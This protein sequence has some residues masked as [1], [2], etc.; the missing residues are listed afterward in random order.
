MS[1]KEIGRCSFLSG[2]NRSRNL[3]KKKKGNKNLQYLTVP[4]KHIML[5]F[6]INQLYTVGT[7]HNLT[8]SYKYQKNPQVIQPSDL[9]NESQNQ[10]P[11]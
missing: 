11:N 9:A 5:H 2:H 6:I 10:H 1:V 4:D 3:L 8:D 7:N